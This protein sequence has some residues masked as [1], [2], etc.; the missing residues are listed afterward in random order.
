MKATETEPKE[1]NLVK[2][3]TDRRQMTGNKTKRKNGTVAGFQ[4]RSK[5]DSMMTSSLRKDPSVAL[6]MVIREESSMSRTWWMDGA[7]LFFG[8][9]TDS[10]LL[11]KVPAAFSEIFKEKKLRFFCCNL[12]LKECFELTVNPGDAIVQK[13]RHKHPVH[14]RGSRHGAQGRQTGQDLPSRT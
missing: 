12:K 13:V 9:I 14:D 5:S 6:M 10:V 4:T 3:V 8:Q 1:L 7:V 11:G 2:K